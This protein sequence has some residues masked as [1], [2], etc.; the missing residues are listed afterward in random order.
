MNGKNIIHKRRIDSVHGRRFGGWGYVQLFK[1]Q[2]FCYLVHTY[3][4]AQAHPHE[5]IKKNDYWF[6]ITS[7]NGYV[8]NIKCNEHG[9]FHCRNKTTPDNLWFGNSIKMIKN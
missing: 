3:T 6:I 1:L 4:H 5:W 9:K 8:E 2:Y 7:I